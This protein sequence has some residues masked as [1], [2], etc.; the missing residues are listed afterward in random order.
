M[1]LKNEW[2]VMQS[3]SRTGNS[4]EIKGGMGWGPVQKSYVTPCLD[5]VSII[6]TATT[7]TDSDT[8]T[9]PAT[10]TAAIATTVTLSA[11]REL[12]QEKF[13]SCCQQTDVILKQR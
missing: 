10:T 1:L 12:K 3:Q 5:P 11:I 13:S 6:S 9:I 4:R 2:Y 7:T 8:A